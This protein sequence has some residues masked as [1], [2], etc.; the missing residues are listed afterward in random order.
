MYSPDVQSSE[1]PLRKTSDLQNTYVISHEQK[2][3]TKK[4]KGL[5]I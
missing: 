4:K 3:K 5:R 2:E 1:W